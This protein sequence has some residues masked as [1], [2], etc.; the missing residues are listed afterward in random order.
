MYLGWKHDDPALKAGVEYLD[1][2]GPT[3]NMYYNYYAT[4]VMRHYG[5][6]FWETWNTKMR[7]RLVT[8]RTRRGTPKAAGTFREIP[9]PTAV[10]DSTAR[11]WPP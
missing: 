2:M 7:D 6:E 5:G 4:Q 9:T 11:R 8:A 1:Q 10:A 3:E